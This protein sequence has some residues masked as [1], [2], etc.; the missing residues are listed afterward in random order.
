[1]RNLTKEMLFNSFENWNV[2]YQNLFSVFMKGITK[3]HKMEYYSFD[4]E[5]ENFKGRATIPSVNVDTYAAEKRAC[6]IFRIEYPETKC[7]ADYLLKKHF[8]EI[9]G[10]IYNQIFK[11]DVLSE[12]ELQVD[13]LIDSI[14]KKNFK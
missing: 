14:I 12:A 4:F 3:N 13:K 7:Y 1:M 9:Y 6:E 5:G 11:E 2:I 10:E 8:P